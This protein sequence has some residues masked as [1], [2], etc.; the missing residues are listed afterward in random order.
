M[1]AG[2]RGMIGG[3]VARRLRQAGHEVVLAGR[4]QGV[5]LALDFNALPPQ[6]ELVRRLRGHDVLVNAVGIFQAQAQ[7]SFDAVHVKAVAALFGAAVQA[8]IGRLLHVSA[9]GAELGGSTAYFDSKGRAEVL[10][11]QLPAPVVIVRPSLVFS[12]QGASSRFFLGLATW[13]LLLLPG[14]GRQPVQPLHL[15]DLAEALARLATCAE[16][17][18]TLEAVGPR[19]LPLRDYL[20]ELGAALGRAPRV[21]SLPM[22]PLRPL[23][24]LAARL[25]GGL[26]GAD[27]LRMLEAGNTGDPDGITAV[28]GRPP[29]DPSV[30]IAAPEAAR[31]RAGLRLRRAVLALRVSL[32]AMWLGTAWV[33]LWGYPREASHALLAR[34]GLHGGVAE[35]ALWSGALLDALLGIAMLLLPRRRPVYYAQLALMAGYTVL[36]SL[37]LPE[38]WLHPFGPLLKNVPIAGAILALILLDRAHGP[39]DR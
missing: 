32:A 25:S 39:G 22:A 1:V 18:D 13:P 21:A 20:R 19:P 36:I 2:G 30:F 7:Q 15:D 9:L 28:L 37:W 8:G 17:P 11:R 38:F 12:P 29:R 34:V 24:P 5:D 3:A 14:G 6:G 31:L 16:P 27:A 4:G 10:L 26:V 23:L 33:S 35:A